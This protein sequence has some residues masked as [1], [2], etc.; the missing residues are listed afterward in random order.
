MLS[1]IEVSM[2]EWNGDDKPIGKWTF[3]IIVAVAVIILIAGVF[4][5]GGD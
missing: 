1:N 5:S 2:G 3:R 4:L